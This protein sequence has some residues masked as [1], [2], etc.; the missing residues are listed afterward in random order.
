MPR[1]TLTPLLAWILILALLPACSVRI[2]T[3]SAPPPPPPAA[4]PTVRTE[5]A[6]IQGLN[7][8]Q[9]PSS[10]TPALGSLDKDEAV[11][12]LERQGNWIR[13]R[14]A[15][16]REGFAY[17]AY[18]TGFDI[19]PARPRPGKAALDPAPSKTPQD[20]SPEEEQELWN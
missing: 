4:A 8:R 20:I 12:V 9:G 14:T 6:T 13:V 3:T 16:G 19:R 18:L 5:R 10:K 1:R 2:G 17:G 15:D 7:L 11:Q